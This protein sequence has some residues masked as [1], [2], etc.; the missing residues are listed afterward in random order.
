MLDEEWIKKQIT[1]AQKL[2][3]NVTT[4]VIEYITEVFLSQLTMQQLTLSELKSISTSILQEM[5]FTSY[6][7]GQKK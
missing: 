2:H 7:M 3:P 5:G 6:E 4:E 1:E